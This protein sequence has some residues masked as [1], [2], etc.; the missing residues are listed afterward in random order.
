MSTIDHTGLH[1]ARQMR[2]IQSLQPL[3]SI[4]LRSLLHRRV[5]SDHLTCEREHPCRQK[6][7]MGVAVLAVLNL[8]DGRTDEFDLA[9]LDEGKQFEDRFSFPSDSE[10]L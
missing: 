10:F 9:R 7:T 6:T 2:G 4:S 1:G 5:N 3:C 8:E